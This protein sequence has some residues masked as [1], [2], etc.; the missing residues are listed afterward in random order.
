MQ[1][2]AQASV[3]PR[4]PAALVPDGVVPQRAG[5][6]ANQPFAHAMQRLEIELFDCF[7]SDKLHR[8]T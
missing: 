8:G 2:Q 6:L 3:L 7:D 4:P 5:A 1:Q